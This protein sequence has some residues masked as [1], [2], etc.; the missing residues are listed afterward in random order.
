VTDYVGEEMN[1][2]DRLKAEGEGRRGMLARVVESGK[3][4]VGDD[5]E[6]L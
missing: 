4:A 6:I 1:R 3:V 5:L 2:A